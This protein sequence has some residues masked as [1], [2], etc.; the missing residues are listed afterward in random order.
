M[1]ENE[2]RALALEV[3]SF[4]LSLR[5][6]GITEEWESDLGCAC[7]VASY[8]LARFL[9][10]KGHTAE[11]V[12]GE[13]RGHTH[14]WVSA[15]CDNENIIID[16]TATQFGRM[17][18]DVEIVDPEFEDYQALHRGKDAELSFIV[19]DWPREQQPQTYIKHIE[20]FLNTS[21]HKVLIHNTFHHNEVHH[22]DQ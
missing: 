1:N 20:R 4:I 17:Y 3:R 21:E 11:L 22:A 8:T 14:C 16:I 9:T 7:A 19:N 6:R 13:F 18:R 10:S 15:V 12:E 5:T 2:C